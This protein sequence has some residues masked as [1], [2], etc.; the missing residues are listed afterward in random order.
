MRPDTETIRFGQGL[1]PP[2][3]HVPVPYRGHQHTLGDQTGQTW[4]GQA[5]PGECVRAADI[6][7]TETA[8]ETDLPPD[9]GQAGRVARLN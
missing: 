8:I 4:A 7:S 6:P 2:P 5:A 1:N 3:N 9:E